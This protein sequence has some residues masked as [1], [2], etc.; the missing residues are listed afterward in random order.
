MAD[1]ISFETG[2]YNSYFSFQGMSQTAVG[3]EGFYQPGL[4]QLN[5]SQDGYLP[6]YY[7]SQTDSNYQGG[8]PF[9]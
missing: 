2:R 7:Q 9:N 3:Y 8:L 4:S 6:V 1:F 5:S